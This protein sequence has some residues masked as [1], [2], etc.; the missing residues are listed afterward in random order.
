VWIP[1]ADTDELGAQAALAAL[2][3]ERLPGWT[4]RLSLT[5]R[6]RH[7]P[8]RTWRVWVDA[9]HLGTSEESVRRSLTGRATP[10]E[11]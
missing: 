7:R 3:R 9:G 2:R 6:G 4:A 8:S 1:V 5:E 11:V 10:P